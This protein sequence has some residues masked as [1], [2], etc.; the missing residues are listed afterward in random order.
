MFGKEQEGETPVAGDPQ[1]TSILARGCKFKGEITVAGTLRVEG[2]FEGSIQKPESLVI[3][4][5]GVVRGDVQVKNAAIGGRVLAH[6]RQHD[7][8][9][10]FQ[11]T[12]LDRLK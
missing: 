12:Q 10:E 4:K 6:R 7:S 2:E 11:L 9:F 1:S 8:V 3:G 5:T